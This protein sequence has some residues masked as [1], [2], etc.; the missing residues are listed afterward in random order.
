M[1][2][3]DAVQYYSW[4]IADSSLLG[5]NDDAIQYFMVNFL[6]N[7]GPDRAIRGIQSVLGVAVDG[8][9]GPETLGAINDANPKELLKSLVHNRMIHYIRTALSRVP[10]ATI[11]T[12][13]LAFLEGWWNR[14][15]H[16]GIEP[17]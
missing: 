4:L 3:D 17:L 7:S 14:C 2:R 9:C 16:E 1:I 10:K 11:V 6:V 13:D 12:T 5:I 8:I 15:Y